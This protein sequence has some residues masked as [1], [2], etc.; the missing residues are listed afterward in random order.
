MF[1][2]PLDLELSIKPFSCISF[3]GSTRINS[4]HTWIIIHS[5]H[6]VPQ[7]LRWRLLRIGLRILRRKLPKVDRVTE[8]EG[9]CTKMPTLVSAPTTS[10][11][12][13]GCSLALIHII[14]TEHIGDPTTKKR[15]S[16]HHTPI[17]S[18]PKRIRVDGSSV[19][20]NG[21][22]RHFRSGKASFPAMLMQNNRAY[23]DRTKYISVLEDIDDCIIFCRPR[24][25]GKSLTI[26]MLEHFHGL[27][28]ANEHQTFYQVCNLL[29]D[30]LGIEN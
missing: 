15:K 10:K 21:T 18:P 3:L 20:F 29:L 4:G 16:P 14:A 8:R 24:R 6:C 12:E 23:F 28:Y 30:Y 5:T 2:I 11:A 27:Q 17:A 25:F 26:S 9:A 1:F 19:I 7:A 22:L 13:P